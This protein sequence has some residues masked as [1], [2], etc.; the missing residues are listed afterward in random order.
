MGFESMELYADL[1][2]RKTAERVLATLRQDGAAVQKRLFSVPEAATYL[3]RT[4]RSVEHMVAH[5]KLPVVKL[6]NRVQIDRYD[7]DRLITNCTNPSV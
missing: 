2:A 3:G 4:V 1:L 7:L 5:R 6:D